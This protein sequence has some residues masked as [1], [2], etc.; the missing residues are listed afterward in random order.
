MADTAS[1]TS[2]EI[3]KEVGS[4]ALDKAW[5]GVKSLADQPQIATPPA[6][7]SVSI[8]SRIVDEHKLSTRGSTEEGSQK[9]KQ[10]RETI[11]ALA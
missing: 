10:H 9:A 5:V 7:D 11:S 8:R 2:A 6:V 4:H 1:D 3:H